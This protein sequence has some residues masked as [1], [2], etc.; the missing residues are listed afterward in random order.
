MSRKSNRRGYPRAKPRPAPQPETQPTPGALSPEE[1]ELFR[2]QA[3]MDALTHLLYSRDNKPQPIPTIEEVRERYAVPVTL[4]GMPDTRERLNLTFDEM[5]GFQAIHSSLLQHL[6]DI[7][8]MPMACFLG[9]GALQNLAQ[10]PLIRACV[11]TVADDLTRKWIEIAGGEE[12]DKDRVTKLTRL[13]KRYRLQTV[14]HDAAVMVGFYG[15]AF[16]FVDTGAEGEDL[17][18]PLPICESGHEIKTCERLAFRVIDPV[19]VTPCDYNCEDPLAPDYM[20]PQH[21]WVL[22]Q[23]VHHSRLLALV[24]NE[25]PTLLK[26]SY[27]F[28]GI[29][30]A[31]LLADYVAHFKEARS[32]E[33]DLLKKISLLVLKTDTDQLFSSPE[34]LRMFDLKAKAL[35]RYRDN[36]SVY[37]CDK[38]FEDVTNVQTSIAGATDIVRQQLEFVA[39]IN[40]TPAVKILGISP[41]GFSATGESDIRNY[42][43]HIRSQQELYRSAITKCLHAVELKHFKSIDNT[44]DFE[45]VELAEDNASAKA[46]NANT[47]MQMYSTGIQCQI[48]SPD[49]ARQAIAQD[50]DMG[51]EFITG[52]APEEEGAD[53]M[54]GEEGGDNP[55]AAMMQQAGGSPEGGAAGAQSESDANGPIMGSKDESKYN[56]AQ[57]DADNREDKQDEAAHQ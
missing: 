39:A 14:F 51:L 30:R 10:D 57:I 27:N 2:Q 42:Y 32:Y 4:A 48:I 37:V 28:L 12:S 56:L 22:G 23:R 11:Q 40:R 1:R 7:G 41:S 18:V 8:Q 13:Q 15:G 21:W 31:Q 55:L 44:I 5:G 17:T 20:R 34:G 24:E 26:P 53:M 6:S 50:P 16:V 35:Q 29:P 36:N 25:P 49:E 9:Y 45:F 3:A 38:N 52:P 19:N 47:R 46:M 43:D 33:I 54:G